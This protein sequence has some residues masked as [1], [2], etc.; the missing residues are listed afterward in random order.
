MIK[1]EISKNKIKCNSET[2]N[3]MEDQTEKKSITELL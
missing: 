1:A 2:S 3:T